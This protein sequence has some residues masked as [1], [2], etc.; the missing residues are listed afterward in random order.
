MSAHTD[1]SRVGAA[2]SDAIQVVHEF[3]REHRAAAIPALIGACVLWAV[4]H[5]GVGVVKGSLRNAIKLA[6]QM[7]TQMAADRRSDAQ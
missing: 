4:E 2:S 1:N 6:D 7:A 5:G 3:V